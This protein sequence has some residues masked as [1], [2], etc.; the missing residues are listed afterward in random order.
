MNRL[1][2]AIVALL[3]GVSC[4]RVAATYRVFN[5]TIDEPGHLSCGLEWL[6][7]HRYTFEYQH[8]PLAR[9]LSAIGPWLQGVKNLERK[10]D[11]PSKNPLI[12]YE[13]SSYY[14]TL[15][16]ARAG[17][18]PFLVM[19]ALAVFLWARELGGDGAAVSAV[20]LF[21]TLPAALGHSGLVTTDASAMAAVPWALYCLDR[22]G[23]SPSMK[24]GIWLGVSVGLGMLCKFSFA[25]FFTAGGLLVLITQRHM[26]R[27]WRGLLVAGVTAFVVIWSG[28]LWSM[29]GWPLRELFL[30]LEE[31]RAHNADGHPS[32]LLGELRLTGWWYF[33][34]VVLFYKTP[35]AFLLLCLA[36]PWLGRRAWL[37]SA[38]GLL[39]LLVVMPSRIN[40]GI[41]HLLPIYPLLAIG[42]GLVLWECLRNRSV[43][44][45][46]GGILLGWQFIATGLAH[47]DYFAYFNELALGEPEEIR[48]DSD[49]DWG[50]NVE[51]IGRVLRER[52]VREPVALGVFSSVDPSRHG[53]E[54]RQASPWETTYGWVAVSAT[55]LKMSAAVRPPGSR[56]RPWTWLDQYT[57]VE[58]IGGSVLLYY[59]PRLGQNR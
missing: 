55:E 33:F 21:L 38:C 49:L 40:L 2:W 58:R 47:P 5:H 22:F 48:V 53:L 11:V 24:R 9:I 43:L 10:E 52:G 31:V 45:Y 13:S 23:R 12:L 57:P 54:W 19:A 4:L 56:L 7:K 44:R 26:L 28:Y 46:V 6:Q 50:Q 34:P 20:A 27:E 15:A 35:L 3:I 37:P 59:I 29:N 39:L 51:R 32:F 8:P 25:V 41:R 17:I 30:G 18:L 36:I 14:D 16:S 1:T 42:A